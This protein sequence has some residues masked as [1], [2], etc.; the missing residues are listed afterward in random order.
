MSGE[1][2]KPRELIHRKYQDFLIEHLNDRNEVIAYLNAALEESFKGD[3]ES[4]IVFL[5]ALR[6]VVVMN[7]GF[8]ELSDK[9]DLGRESLYKTLSGNGNP[10]WSTI[11]NIL[12][13]LKLDLKLEKR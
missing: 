10:K 8:Q 3:E 4:R 11:V 6:N 13:V 7:G 9:T 1:C 5:T 12:K 2:D